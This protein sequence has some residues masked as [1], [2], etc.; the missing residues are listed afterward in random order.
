MGFPIYLVFAFVL[1]LIALAEFTYLTYR[2]YQ[3]VQCES[4][5]TAWCWS[6]W[7]CKNDCPGTSSPCY[8]TASKPGLAACLYGPGAFSTA[9]CETGG[10]VCACPTAGATGSNC[11]AGCPLSLKDVAPAVTCCTADNPC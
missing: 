3:V 4:D 10:G 9:G 6:D 7:V 5:P 11:L 8:D 2:Y 1:V